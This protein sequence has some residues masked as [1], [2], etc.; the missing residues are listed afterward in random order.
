M[1]T[2]TNQIRL[3]SGIPNIANISPQE[4]PY[5]TIGFLLTAN[6][7]VELAT[8]LLAAAREWDEI[9]VTVHRKGSGRITVLPKHASSTE[10][11][12]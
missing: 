5:K 8:L 9:V 12:S 10:T 7:A 11:D 3:S 6:Q 4:S 2:S 1:A